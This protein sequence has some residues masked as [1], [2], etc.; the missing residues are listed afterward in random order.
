MPTDLILKNANVITMDPARPRAELAA[1]SGDAIFFTGGN[2]EAAR[3]TGRGTRVIDCGGRTLVPGFNDAHLHL[4]SLA[5]KLLSIDL[6]PAAVRSVEDIKETVRRK[7]E[8]TPPGAWISGTDYNEFYLEGRRCPTRA[9][10]DEVAPDHPVVLS[11]R[12]LHACVLN[13]KALELAGIG[14]DTPEPEGGRIER[15][16][17]T[18]EPN[19]ALIDMLGYV[20]SKIVSPITPREM[21]RAVGE[22]DKVFLSYGITSFTEA[23]VSN[24]TGRW[25]TV[26]GFVLDRKLRSR[27]TMMAGAPYREEFRERGLKTGSGDSLMQ[28]GA[29]KI[30]PEVTPEPAELNEL[31]L[32]CH[33]R[34]WQIAVHAIAESTVEAAVAALE[35]AAKYSPA[36]GQRH[37]IEHCAECPPALLERMKKLGAVI[38][39]Q[40]PF[41]YYSGERYLAT[42][43]E[44]QLPWLYR[45]KTP[46]EKGVMVAGS[47]DAPVV[48]NNPL[49]GIY[50]AVTR[51]AESGQALLPEEKITPE[52]SLALYTVNAAYASFEENIKGSLAPGK[53]ADMIILSADP[54]RVPPEEIK[55]I[56]V[57]MTIIGGEVVWE[58]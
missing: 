21:D 20:R 12:S 44:S 24:D 19:G 23:T 5:R 39:T 42:V 58:K 7:A 2:D 55:D 53:L 14:R 38:V 9:D 18:G 41:I 40:P 47:S 34:G 48:P 43:P 50:A 57:E 16:L 13:S 56:K 26:C 29:V 33:R 54:T 11:H 37:R 1:V 8:K 22:A 17:A 30:M 25:E 52:Q 4:F 10:L 31:V 35:N 32:D 45:L 51:R 15:D 27:V 49:T 36:S 28:L 3:L 46:L 6:S